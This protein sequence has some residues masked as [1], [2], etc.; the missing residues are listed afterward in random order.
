METALHRSAEFSSSYY[1]SERLVELG[2]Q[3]LKHSGI[4]ESVLGLI[5]SRTSALYFGMSVKIR[6][7][8]GWLDL[9][10]SCC[11]ILLPSHN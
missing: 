4:S 9:L 6:R 8:I 11:D 3:A 7:S 2:E 1:L 10:L 5:L